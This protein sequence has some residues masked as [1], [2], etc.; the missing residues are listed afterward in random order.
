MPYQLDP[1]LVAYTTAM[2]APRPTP[3]RRDDWRTL[4]EQGELGMAAI[5]AMLPE[6]PEVERTDHQVA[7]FGG[8]E[9]MVREYGARPAHDPG[10]AVVYV[11]GG[12]M[13]MGS[14]AGY[15]RL[16]ARYVVESEVPFF[17]VD[18][19]RAPEHPH[20]APVE[21]CF[22]ALSWVMEHAA[23]LR[24]D[25]ARVAIMGDSAGGGLAAGVALL[26]RDRGV[27]L[28][29]QVLVYPML[30]DRSTVPDPDLAPFLV[31]SYDDNYTGW[32]ALLGDAIG[33]DSV[34]AAAAPARAA[35]VSGLP[36]TF[37]DVGGLDLFRDES[38]DYARRITATATPV[39]LHVHPGC[40]HGYDRMP[41]PVA[42]RAFAD[43]V[44]VL[45]RL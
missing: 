28:A 22:T 21:D 24:V 4:R 29:H 19:R 17:S 33:T 12:G 15:D 1:D 9:I 3:A 37:I 11:H 13:L 14:V 20:P 31:W 38:I 43:R 42:E 16:V 26:A 6:R 23:E 36:P 30:D 32:H 44:R 8:A 7:S 5:D 41:I 10:P 27:P 2:D 39:E 40:P 45:R 35:D 25:P 34:P 18:Y